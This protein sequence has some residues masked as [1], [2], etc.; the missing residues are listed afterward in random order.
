M[1]VGAALV[2]MRPVV[3]LMYVD[4]VTLAM[5]PLVNQAAKLRYMFG[6]QAAVPLVVRSN[7]GASG[8]KA[9]QHSQ[10]LESWLVHVPGL[11]VVLP[12][13]PYDAKG[14][15]ATAIRD[16]NPVVFLEHKLLYFAKGEVPEGELAIPFG[17]AAVRRPGRD[18]TVVAFQSMLALALR[19][20]DELA[21][22][23]IEV[24]VV[25]PRTL[26]P[27][28]LEAIVASVKR[29]NRLLICHEATE[30]G[31]WAGEVAM[32]VM[33]EAF[34]FLDA[35]ISRVC[36]ANVP[37]PYSGSLEPE[38]I[39]SQDDI[40][41][42]VRRLVEGA[43]PA[44]AGEDDF[45]PAT[46]APAPH[47]RAALSRGQGSAAGRWEIVMP[48]LSDTM[49]EG[50]VSRWLK[51]VGDPVAKGEAVVEIET[52]KATLE[53]AAETD[54]FLIEILVA[55]GSEAAIGTEIGLIAAE[56]PV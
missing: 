44:A 19:A 7:V 49:T 48:R 56:T 14:L 55:A 27:L 20:A 10:S 52:E 50:L 33:Q 42:A 43:T 37:V 46:G 11:K 22:E 36:G 39:P 5:E 41:S 47:K 28:D 12:G 54:G 32:Q 45:R 18:A 1:G 30:R 40:A 35:P 29:T 53:I 34:D 25:D 51:A 3:E 8:G 21:V 9:A 13:T 38:V 24:E 4:F 15:L 2:G 17:E 23:G 6:G 31:G 26:V 16:D